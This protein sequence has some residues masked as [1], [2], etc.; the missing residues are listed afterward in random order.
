MSSHDAFRT[1]V[2]SADREAMV[3]ALAPDV[4]FNSPVKH[5]PF[6]GKD[7]VSQVLQAAFETFEYFRYVADLPGEDVHG[8][9]FEARVGDR[10][11]QGIDLFR[12]S[13]EGLI[14]ELTV[15][16]RPASAVMAMGE[17]MGPKLAHLAQG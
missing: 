15:M 16:L 12:V 6:E 1:A 11:V 13:D 3:A 4:V 10:S 9:M 17:A 7:A 14:A 5:K 8:L 2:E